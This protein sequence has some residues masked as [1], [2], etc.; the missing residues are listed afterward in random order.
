MQDDPFAG[1][2]GKHLLVGVTTVGA[3]GE[4]I[5]QRQFHGIIETADAGRG[6][7]VRRADDDRLEH[8]PPD[9]RAIRQAPPGEY[10]LRSSETTV[11]DPDLLAT[12][13][14]RRP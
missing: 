4:V 8:L 1:L 11:N 7:A 13:T 10:R 14:V 9:L 2:L 12:W 3:D 6:I 5:E